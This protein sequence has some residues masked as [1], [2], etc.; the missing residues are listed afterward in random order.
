MVQEAVEWFTGAVPD[1]VP[2]PDLPDRLVVT[3]PGFPN[4]GSAPIPEL[5]RMSLPAPP[6]TGGW[7]G[8]GPTP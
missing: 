1:F 2:V 6:A 3:A 5:P 4:R 7:N 8:S